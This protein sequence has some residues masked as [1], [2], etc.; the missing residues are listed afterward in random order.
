MFHR[1]YIFVDLADIFGKIFFI[2]VKC[3]WKPIEIRRCMLPEILTSRIWPI[4][5]LPT[6]SLQTF[7]LSKTFPPKI[8]VWNFSQENFPSLCIPCILVYFSFYGKFADSTETLQ[9]KIGNSV[10]IRCNNHEEVRAFN[11]AV[12][13]FFG[14]VLPRGEGT[15]WPPF[16]NS[17]RIELWTWNL[18]EWFSAM[19]QIKWHKKN[20][21]MVTSAVMTSLII[22]ALAQNYAKKCKNGTISKIEIVRV[23][24]KVFYFSFPFLKAKRS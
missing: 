14:L 16:L 6:I 5:F 23:R 17:G 21:N 20:F 22:R 9:H 24:K 13:G 3:I 11:L 19:L 1:L 15:M 7:N 12:P 10:T 8:F 4:F 2:S 18:A